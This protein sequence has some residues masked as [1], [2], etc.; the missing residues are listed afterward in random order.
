MRE[1]LYAAALLIANESRS[2]QIL[3]DVAGTWPELALRAP[4]FAFRVSAR[5]GRSRPE[6]RAGR[7]PAGSETTH[8]GT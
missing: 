6:A 4:V 2:K 1:K 8:G 7:Q 5:R 3:R